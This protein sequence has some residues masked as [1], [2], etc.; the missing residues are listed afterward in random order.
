MKSL[1]K[2]LSIFLLNLQRFL[3]SLNLLQSKQ[4]ETV[5]IFFLF[6]GHLMISMVLDNA[7]VYEEIKM[8]VNKNETN[9][10]FDGL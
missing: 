2:I 7:Y 5:F 4:S 8:N 1:F 10:T 9:C 3:T 6:I